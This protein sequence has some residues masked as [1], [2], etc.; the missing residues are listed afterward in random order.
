MRFRVCALGARSD[1]NDA[2]HGWGGIVLHDIIN[3]TFAKKGSGRAH[4]DECPD[5]SAPAECA[6]RL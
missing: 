4:C 1:V 6:K 2:V 3:N 5:T